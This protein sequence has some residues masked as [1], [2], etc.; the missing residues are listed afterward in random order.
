MVKIS[1]K[2][3][4]GQLDEGYAL[5][6]HTVRS[7]FI[8]YDGYGHPQFD[9][10]RTEIG[11]LLYRLKSGKDQSVIEDIVTIA[12]DFVQSKRN[13]SIELVIPVPPSSIRSSQP[14]IVLAKKLAKALGVEYCSDCVK[15]IKNTPQL[16]NVFDAEERRKLLTGAF[17]ADRSK[18]QGKSVLLFDDLYRSGATMNEVSSLLQ[19]SGKAEYIYALALTMTTVHR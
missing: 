7:D 1:P 11:E 10:K 6:F 17:Q 12:A 8:G 19:K 4:K 13:W 3:I 2:K 5:D 16:K 9:T 15:K 18:I 14:I